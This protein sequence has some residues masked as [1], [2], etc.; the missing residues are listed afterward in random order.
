MKLCIP[1]LTTSRGEGLGNEIIPWAKA[2][3]ASRVLSARLAHPAWG[4]N[5]RGYWRNF[6]TSRYDW[7]IYRPL[8]ETGIGHE[9]TEQDYYRHGGRSYAEAIRSWATARGLD[10]KQHFIVWSSGMWGGF[11]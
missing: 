5:A 3:L 2:F 7:W 9:F 11:G 8:L 10:R 6:G 1:K 4:R